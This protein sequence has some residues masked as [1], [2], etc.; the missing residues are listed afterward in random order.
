MA[1]NIELAK[2]YVTIVPTTTGMQ[3]ALT[4]E[5]SGASEAAGNTA[6]GSFSNGFTRSL[7]TAGRVA[8]AALTAATTATR[9]FAVTAIRA[10]AN[11]DSSMSQV[12][13]TMG[14]T[15]E[16]INEI[17]GDFDRL[18]EAA[19]QYGAETAFSATQCAEALN[20]MALAGYDADT[21]IEM[22]P[23][24]LALAAA[25]N[26]D[27]ARASDMVTDTQT[28]FGI[29]LERTNQMVDEMAKAA[30]TGNT[31]VEQLGDAFLTV[32]GLAAELNG[33]VVLLDDGTS[34]AVD[35][36]QELEIAL[37]AM[38]NAGIKGSEAG[39]HMRNMLLK[40][41]D[42]TSDGAA[43]L[44]A[45]GVNIWD[46]E[47][48]MLALSDIM[49]QL[50]N[51][52][53]D[54][55]QEEKI[56]AISDL[57]NT[58]D[59]ASAEAL[60][61]AIDEDW[62]DIGEAI[63]NADGAAQQMADTQL[64]NLSGDITIFRSALEGTQIAISDSLSPTL[65]DF[66]QMGSEGLQSVTA[67][68]QEGGLEGAME[69]LGTWLSDALSKVLEMTPEIVSAGMQLLGALGQGLI[70]NA[71]LIV[72]STLEVAQML[73][74]SFE[75]AVNGDG[76][77]RLMETTME[78][79]GMLGEFLVQNAPEL[80]GTAS[81]LISQLILF[82]T[83][84]ANLDMM[85]EMALQLTV[86][87]ADGLVQAIPNLI[88]VI[89]Q[90]IGALVISIVDE[91]PNI[92][93]TIGDLI[94]DLGLMVLGL[95]GGLMGQSYDEVMNNLQL[96]LDFV[97][98]SFDDFISGLTGWIS[99]IGTYISGMWTDIKDWF[100]GG[101]S[102]A[103]E[104]LCGW[105][106]E[107]SEWFSDLAENALT[108]AGDMID[109][110]V[111]GITAGVGAVGDAISSVASTV[112]DFLGFSEPEKGPLSNFHTYAPDMIDLFNEGVMEST[113]ELEAT[114][115]RTLS[116]PALG[117]VS[118]YIPDGNGASSNVGNIVIPVNIGQ[119]T[120]ETVIVTAEQLETFRRGG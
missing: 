120:L 22:L 12:A 24:V 114:L 52:L 5:L 28:A 32:G 104:A 17:G 79:V 15:E 45:L 71:P 69:A 67:G 61:S 82:I 43:Q 11:F 80:I 64:D 100:T 66:V 81:E 37:T 72:S 18:R 78:I 115:N 59:V 105:W 8:G 23:N 95:V 1:D 91:F 65:R 85:I 3:N 87:I 30:S 118:E 88:S 50:S 53:G 41:M 86:A 56:S 33:G 26:M 113:P 83:D 90:V 62:D 44:E 112:R 2:A 16:Q 21:S 99:D 47:G 116:L 27:L 42:P 68:F 117:S 75:D 119:E 58:R 35:G 7:G 89:P 51:S 96:V 101:I 94:G 46:T 107:I 102:D 54:L 103:M 19:Q 70:D 4:R 106:D 109:N 73:I 74:D 39:T 34:V 97:A 98:Q 38:A 77:S 36:V 111:S 48:N 60:L 93:L 29:S 76:A 108:W 63:L 31:S 9:T 10:G 14:L 25:G 40:L 84:P 57:F 55:T 6:G 92:L 49:T 13:A 110:F 20:Y